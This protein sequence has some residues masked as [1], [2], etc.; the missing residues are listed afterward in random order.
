LPTLTDIRE[1]AKER[2]PK[3]VLN[4]L[5][6][7]CWLGPLVLLTLVAVVDVTVAVMSR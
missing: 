3:D 7:T 5:E 4:H 6:V 1:Y 2:F